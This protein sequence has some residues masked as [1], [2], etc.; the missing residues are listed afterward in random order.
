MLIGRD[1]ELERVGRALDTARAGGSAALVLTGQPGIGKTALLLAALERAEGMTVLSV[2]GLEAE[3]HQPFAGLAELCRPVVSLRDRLPAAQ[4]AALAGALQLE[5][6]APQARLAIG[7]A[8]LGLLSLAAEERPVVCM[9]DDLQWLDEPSLEALRFATR[10]LGAEGVAVLL[11]QRP[12]PGELVPGVETLQVR[13][14]SADCAQELLDASRD[15]PVPEHVARRVLE[16]AAGN[17]LALREIPAL[18]SHDELEGRA[19]IEGPLP[20][21]STL[22]RVLAR[23]LEVLEDETRRALLVAAAAEVRRGDLVLR[24]LTAA[25]LDVGALEPAEA[26]GIVTLGPG[27]V[28]FRHPL[29]R[30]A[31]YHGGS[32]VERRAA[33]RAV[34]QA[35]PEDDPQRAWQLAAGTG[36]PDESVAAALEG[37]ALQARART[38]FA[39]AAHAHLRAAELSP[40]PVERARRLVEAA[41]D[42]LPAGYPEVGL[43]RL[44]QAERVLAIADS[45]DVSAVA[46]D[47]RTLRAQ[48]ALR[49]G[50]IAEAREM[51]RAQARRLQVEAP[52]TAA[53]L[54][55]LSSLGSMALRDHVGWLADAERALA[56]SGDAELLAALAGL[57]AGAA[58]MTV[59][60]VAAGRALLE[61]GEQ[62][63]GE[64]LGMALSLAPELVALAGHGW[65][66]IEEY[67]RGVELL[68][69]LVAAGRESASV[70]ALP[71]P[72]A[73]RAQGNLYLGHYGRALAD[74][75]EAVALAEQTGQDPALV[76]ALGILAT[77]RAWHGDSDAANDA[78]AQ[79]LA[80]AERRRV[81]LPAIYAHYALAM[82]AVASDRAEEAVERLELVR[83][84]ALPGN[85]LWATHLVDAY[86]RAG[87]RDDATALVEHY[88]RS[89]EHRR[90]APA[91]LERVR[92]LIAPADQAE[93]H[94]QA[95]LDLHAAG[96]APF[97]LA[98]TRLAYGEWLLA[99]DRRDDAREQLRAALAGFEQV[100]ALPF[101]EHARHTLRAAG[102]ATRA[103]PERAADLTPHE[104]RVAQLVAQGL[105]NREAAAALFVSAKTI[106]HHLRN[107]FRKLGIRRRAELARLMAVR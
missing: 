104:L 41:R 21:G 2:R 28:A 88:A 37:V 39:P 13:S 12:V 79:A 14:L 86:V 78:A 107:V 89:I 95:A 11:S 62:R 82:L 80:L 43:A 90:I 7:A 40:N 81:P 20:P 92:A 36:R 74:A 46:A 52:P 102:A 99:H 96:P 93:A 26:A 19:P 1:V 84:E 18:L 66:W 59:P 67:E 56:L 30:A 61:D 75:E 47:L 49:T 64:D 15:Q 63:L 68:D 34:A 101:A 50:R 16:T 33:H 94:F 54:L 22:E 24:A 57:S 9:V 38:G 71:Y 31:A 6:A 70:G 85:V 97:E 73:A 98:R 44:E 77:V 42:L 58:R 25:G 10:R 32:V 105:T 55:L 69:R 17:P 87:R 60:D 76:I 3:A 103:A 65:L 8:L 27:E 35:L 53:M 91:M 45:G 51:L 23:R 29:L 4:A 83:A 106:E 72:L 48:L 100:E 5:P